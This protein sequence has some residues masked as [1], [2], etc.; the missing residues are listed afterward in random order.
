MFDKVMLL[1]VEPF[2]YV[3][4]WLFVISHDFWRTLLS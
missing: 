3:T 2:W 1:N 4:R